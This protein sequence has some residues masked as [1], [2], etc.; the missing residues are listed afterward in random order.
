MAA[1]S[2]LVQAPFDCENRLPG[3][4]VR[5]EMKGRGE[6]ALNHWFVE[7]VN[8]VAKPTPLLSRARMVQK[9]TFFIHRHICIPLICIY[10]YGL[11]EG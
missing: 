10:T 4:P 11:K 5:K 3:A 8:Q 1:R 9:E 6:E 2:I 7:V